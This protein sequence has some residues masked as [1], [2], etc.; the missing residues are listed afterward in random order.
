MPK[1]T[2]L[3]SGGHRIQRLTEPLPCPFLDATSRPRGPK[4]L[5]EPGDDFRRGKNTQALK[6]ILGL[7]IHIYKRMCCVL[8]R[9]VVSDSL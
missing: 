5:E 8:S 1:I 6:S 7:T 9:S 2:E 3:P 4:A